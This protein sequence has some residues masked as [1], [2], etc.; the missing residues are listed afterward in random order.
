MNQ[1]ANRVP[2]AELDNDEPIGDAVEQQQ[3]VSDEPGPANLAEG[4]P[5]DAPE[6]DAVEQAFTVG[7]DDEDDYR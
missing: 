7:H 6:A 1:R 5:F 2:D 4:V 3:P